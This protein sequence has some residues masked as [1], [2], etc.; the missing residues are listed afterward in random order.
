MGSETDFMTPVLMCAVKCLT[1]MKSYIKE[2][3]MQL[4]SFEIGERTKKI[5]QTL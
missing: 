5:L 1:E 3:R 2:G 4:K